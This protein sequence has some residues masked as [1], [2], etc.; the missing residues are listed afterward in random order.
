MSNRQ[1][2][3]KANIQEQQGFLAARRAQQLIM[4]EQAYEVGLK[5]YEDNKDK[6]SPEEI[7]MI[8]K[9]KAEQLSLLEQLRNE[10]NQNPEA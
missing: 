3:I 4:L 5:I 2:K 6:M 9:L 8:E 10:V 1:D 7:E